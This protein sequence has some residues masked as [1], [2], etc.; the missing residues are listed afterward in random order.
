MRKLF[1][2]IIGLYMAGVLFAFE[3]STVQ[4]T[5]QGDF[6][7]VYITAKE[8]LTHIKLHLLAPDGKLHQ[9]IAAFPVDTSNKKYIAL[10]GIPTWAAVGDWTIQVSAFE[11]V[12]NSEK[13]IPLSIRATKFTE[14]TLKLNES[15]TNLITKSDP[16]KK[17]ESRVLTELLNNVNAQA[18]AYQKPFTLPTTSTRITS[19]FG[20][21][22]KLVY[23]TGKTGSE[24]HW[25]IDFGIPEG[26][27]LVSPV[28]GT[29]VFSDERIVTGGTLIIEA[30]PGVYSIFYH[31]S[32]RLK[33]VGDVVSVGEIIARS[34]SS[35]YATG[36]HLHWEV[37]MNGIPISPYA[38]AEKALWISEN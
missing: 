28:N 30:A 20:E 8:N 34:G 36:P 35:G 19:A 25:G 32:K 29:V 27:A 6:I 9:S 18:T 7:T 3:I 31:L 10:I 2:F 11:G 22:R 23:N 26:T 4:E 13:T 15:N 5:S 38:V 37:R 24:T 1:A 12:H 16:K 17:E 14:Y 21:K 33:S